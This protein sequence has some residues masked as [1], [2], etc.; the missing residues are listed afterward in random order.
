MV[1]RND[2]FKF[3]WWCKNR[4]LILRMSSLR[5]CFHEAFIVRN[6]SC[7][8]RGWGHGFLVSGWSLGRKLNLFETFPCSF[9]KDFCAMWCIHTAGLW[10][11][12]HE[13][14]NG[15]PFYGNYST[16]DSQ[17]NTVISHT[18]AYSSKWRLKPWQGLFN[19]V[20]FTADQ[21][22]W[23]VLN[24]P[25]QRVFWRNLRFILYSRVKGSTFLKGNFCIYERFMPDF[26][27]FWHQRGRK[28]TKCTFEIGFF[29]MCSD[30]L[31]PIILMYFA[32]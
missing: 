24:Q 16:L 25:T 11:L 19:L 20:F 10:M 9:F 22:A 5:S 17:T 7:F 15:Q 26:Y 6:R 18:F 8:Y 3:L 13:T 23:L 2:E 14:G 31:P 32:M 4:A 21:S 30:C 1:I 12:V 29:A 28:T 27:T